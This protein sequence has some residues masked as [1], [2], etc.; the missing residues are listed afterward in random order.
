MILEKV[1]TRI[2][3]MVRN[4]ILR[5]REEKEKLL[6]IDP[7][8]V[9]RV[10]ASYGTVGLT[11]NLAKGQSIKQARRACSRKC[12]LQ[13]EAGSV[14]WQASSLSVE[15]KQL[16]LLSRHEY[17]SDYVL[18]LYNINVYYFIG[19]CACVALC[20]SSLER[21]GLDESSD[22]VESFNRLFDTPLC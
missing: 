3:E 5:K 10:E 13:N 17:I 7:E 6:E 16:P 4:A 18:L 2:A 19:G 14:I 9:G 22:A 8:R 20:V 15:R 12:K 21:T 11:I 1:D